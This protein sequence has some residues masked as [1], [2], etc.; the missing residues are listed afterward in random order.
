MTDLNNPVTFKLTDEEYEWYLKDGDHVS[1]SAARKNPE[2]S[3][4]RAMIENR[5]Y[6]DALS[7]NGR[8]VHEI[9][10]GL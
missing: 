9:I 8:R 10:K 7:I 4:L 2:K 6:S 5:E 3:M 1:N